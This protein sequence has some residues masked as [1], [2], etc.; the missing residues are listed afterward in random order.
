MN[1]FEQRM[2]IVDGATVYRG[3]QQADGINDLLGD[4][5]ER[6]FVYSVTAAHDKFVI[7]LM[8]QTTDGMVPIEDDE[9][10]N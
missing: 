4:E 3:N 9:N 6:W 2:F 10:S 8:R 7:V 5:A 1:G